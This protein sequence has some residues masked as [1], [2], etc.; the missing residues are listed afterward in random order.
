[1]RV[2]TRMGEIPSVLCRK[3]PEIGI[4][5]LTHGGNYNSLGFFCT[6]VFRVDL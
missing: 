4:S 3:S 5:L 6:K 2:L 1:M